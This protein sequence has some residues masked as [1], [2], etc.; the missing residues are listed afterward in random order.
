[1]D[2]EETSVYKILQFIQLVLLYIEK[3]KK[4]QQY[5]NMGV[6]WAIFMGQRGEGGKLYFIQHKMLYKTQ[7]DTPKTKDQIYLICGIT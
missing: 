4:Q 7:F 6:T 1:M 5:E 3:V 2:T